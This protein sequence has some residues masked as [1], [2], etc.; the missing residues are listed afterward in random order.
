MGDD[1]NISELIARAKAGDE[2]A[3]REFLTRFEPEVRIIVRGH[4]PRALRTRFDSLDFVQSVWETFF[5][6]LRERPD[7]FENVQHLRGFLAGVARNKVYAEHRRQTAQKHSIAREEPLY[8]R[9]GNREVEREVVSP[10]HTPSKEMQASE[11][12]A[13]LIAGC[14][15]LEVQVITLRHDGM[16]FEQIASRTG[17]HER[18][19]RRIIDQARARM[20]ARG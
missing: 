18:S 9:R 1:S 16:T 4:L 10:E 13:Q 20:E 5:A 7:N 14:T 6:Q 12:L 2:A 15:P 19:V 11:R 8:I 3:I 17:I